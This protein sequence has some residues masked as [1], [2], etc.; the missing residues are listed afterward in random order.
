MKTQKRTYEKNISYVEHKK[1]F[2][3]TLTTFAKYNKSISI[4]YDTSLKRWEFEC[5]K[6]GTS[7]SSNNQIVYDIP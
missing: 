1:N 7:L 4:K 2:P 6:W 3:R 5:I